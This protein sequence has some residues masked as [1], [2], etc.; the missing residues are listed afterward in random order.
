MTVDTL[1]QNLTNYPSNAL[2]RVIGGGYETEV[3]DATQL[4]VSFERIGKH[5]PLGEWPTR[6]AAAGRG[7]RRYSVRP[8]VTITG[9]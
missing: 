3:V 7:K 6:E 2:V 8:V 4:Q 9:D 5:G 1:I